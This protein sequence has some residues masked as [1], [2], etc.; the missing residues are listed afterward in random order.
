MNNKLF[1]ERN[2][3]QFVDLWKDS[4]FLE[5]TF[6]TLYMTL[7][8]T[9]VAYIFGLA[10]GIVLYVT[11]KNGIKPMPILNKILGFVVN[12]LRSIPFVILIVALMPFTY[13]I[14]GTSV[15]NM[16]MIVT[17]IIA[18]A[19]YIARVVEQS[20]NEVNHGV[21]EAA[22]AMGANTFQIIWKVLLPEAKPSLVNGFIICIVTIIGYTAMAGS[23][24]AEGLGQLA[25]DSGHKKSNYLVVWVCIIIIVIIVQLIQEFG[26]FISKKIDKRIR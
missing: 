13:S 22:E 24:G 10:I 5:A 18:S 16:P 20:L 9:A 14:I 23:I 4:S 12:I 17:L 25:I 1:S 2:I 6:I 26:T 19:P 3:Q 8:S 15:G 21:I 11:S 7:I